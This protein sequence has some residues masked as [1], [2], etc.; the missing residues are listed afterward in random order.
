MPSTS[1]ISVRR[2]SV[3]VVQY[4]RDAKPHIPAQVGRHETLRRSAD[5]AITRSS[6]RGEVTVTPCTCSSSAEPGSS[7]GRWPRRRST[8]ATRS[9]C[10]IA[11][12]RLP[13]SSR[14]PN[15]CSPTGTR[16]SPC[17]ADREFD[18]T[19]DVCAYLP[20]QVESLPQGPGRPRRP[21]RLHLHDVGVRRYGPARPGRGRGARRARRIPTSTQVT[22]ETYGGLKVLC[23]RAA[24]CRLRRGA[25]SR[26]SGRHTSSAR[27]TTPSVSLG[28]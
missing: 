6:P 26:S 19:V 1:K 10:C 22:N 16:T 9:P 17:S 23:E 13:T 4:P 11:A 12:R 5:S 18:A 8:Q 15:T 7:A 27:T 28:G 25:T 14:M 2:S 24:R 3:M 20:R 21:P